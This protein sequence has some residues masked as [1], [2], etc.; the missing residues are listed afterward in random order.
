MGE[1]VRPAGCGCR[2]RG[3]LLTTV[4]SFLKFLLCAFPEGSARAGGIQPRWAYGAGQPRPFGP[5]R[6]G[7]AAGTRLGGTRLSYPPERCLKKQSPYMQH[8]L[9]NLGLQLLCLSRDEGNHCGA[10]VT[11]SLFFRRKYLNCLSFVG[12]EVLEQ[13]HSCW[14]RPQSV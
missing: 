10:V 2:A 11:A 14:W 4:R 12:N 9:C 6:G 5:G 3:S 8:R 13:L 1:R 7:S